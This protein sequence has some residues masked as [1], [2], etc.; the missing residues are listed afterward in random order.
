M[1]EEGRGDI[2]GTVLQAGECAEVETRVKQSNI[3]LSQQNCFES[4]LNTVF[5]A[6][7]TA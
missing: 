3:I 5:K 6:V 4:E 7:R 1:R 2:V